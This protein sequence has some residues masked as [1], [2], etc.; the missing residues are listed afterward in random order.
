MKTASHLKKMIFLVPMII[1]CDSEVE[2]PICTRH[3]VKC[4][5]VCIFIDDYLFNGCKVK[6]EKD[7]DGN[8]R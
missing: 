6:N 8:N 4:G 2:E 7:Y 1:A 5:N 3:E